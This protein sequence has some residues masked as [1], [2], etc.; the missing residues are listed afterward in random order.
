VPD[1]NLGALTAL[2]RLRRVETD[3]ARR[4]LGEALARETALVARDDALR[5]ELDEA[6]GIS[7]DFDR[8]AFVAWFGRMLAERAR[9]A[10]RVRDAE[11]HAAAARTA[12]ARRRVAET[13][14]GEALAV[15]LAAKQAAVAHREQ[16]I[17]ED[18]ARA[19]RR[20]NER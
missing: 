9:L 8:E 2:R 1:P 13:A 19:L 5:R 3:A 16:L 11:A 10:D 15:A 17:L 20:A 6:R 18:V 12:L 7:G 14:A 4:H